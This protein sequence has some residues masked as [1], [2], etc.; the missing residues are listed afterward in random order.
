MLDAAKAAQLQ[1]LSHVQDIARYEETTTLEDLP[2]H[3]CAGM[4]LWKR[5]MY[6]TCDVHPGVSVLDNAKNWDQRAFDTAF[7]LFQSRNETRPFRIY[8]ITNQVGGFIQSAWPAFIETKTRFVLVLGASLMK[9]SRLGTDLDTMLNSPLFVHAFACNC[10][11]KD[12]R[13]TQ[14]PL[15]VDYHSSAARSRPA[16]QNVDLLHYTWKDHQ[17][18]QR[19]LKIIYN[20]N[21]GTNPSAR[22]D[23]KSQLLKNLPS[24]YLQEFRFGTSRSTIWQATAKTEFMVSP[25]GA[26]MDCHRHWEIIALGAIPII[27]R[28]TPFSELYDDLPAVQV[29]SYEE[30]TLDNLTRWKQEYRPKIEAFINAQD[31]RLYS[32]YYMKQ[33]LQIS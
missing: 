27:V 8:L 5:C 33:V 29:D 6:A 2:N 26:G 11:V 9:V 31:R 24:Q 32:D 22:R 17:S 25:P 15:G 30:V 23:V 16:N 28:M 13:I 20:F 21:V 4:V 7:K 1:K 19:E 14:V 18:S 12:P 3:P 10:D